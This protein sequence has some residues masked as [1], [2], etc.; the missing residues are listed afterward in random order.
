MLV[1]F[2]DILVYSK[3][4]DE[5]VEHL[6]LVLRLMKENKLYA[7]L[8]ECRFE[9]EQLEYLGHTISKEGVSAE[10]TKIE[11]MLQWTKP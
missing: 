7:K 11:A 9:K 1:I 6:S 5:H 3:C 8:S 10:P 4:Q 2:D